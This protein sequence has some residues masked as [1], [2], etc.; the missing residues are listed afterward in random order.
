[1]HKILLS[2]PVPEVIGEVLYTFPLL[3]VCNSCNGLR[4]CI[5]EHMEFRP[6]ASSNYIVGPKNDF[7][8]W[9]QGAPVRRCVPLWT[10]S[11]K[12]SS[13]ATSTCNTPECST[14][15]HKILQ[16]P[17]RSLAFDSSRLQQSAIHDLICDHSLTS[18]WY[19]FMIFDKPAEMPT[20]CVEPTQGCMGYCAE[21]VP[22]SKSQCDD[23]EIKVNGLC[24]SKFNSQSLI[25]E[26]PSTPEIVPERVGNSVHLKCYF[27]S[28]LT[29]SSLGFIVRWSRLSSD[30]EKEELRQEAVVQPFSII[31]LDGI[32]VKLGERIFCS[33]SSFN[34]EEPDVH[35]LILESEEFFAGIKL[36]PESL[37]ISEDGREHRMTVK[38]TIPISCS[39]TS[40]VQN[41][42]KVTI[43]FHTV[44]E[45]R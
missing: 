20:K 25:P 16:N 1:N 9:V 43:R 2:P 13:Q 38:S 36:H 6:S 12:G 15:G 23:G 42:C 41:D 11:Q 18:G 19:R 24:T 3:M 28:P 29:N 31:E 32:N 35:S 34:L 44:D 30:G 33:I 37:R 40:Q 26:S 21:V 22:E 4:G 7:L 45:G 5:R 8:W 17:Y 10:G 27:E 39:D 14:T